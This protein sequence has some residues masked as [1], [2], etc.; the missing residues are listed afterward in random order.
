MYTKAKNKILIKIAVLQNLKEQ[1]I[2]EF[3]FLHTQKT[4]KAG[5]A[6]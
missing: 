3:F 4:I 5:P 1:K 2:E 6:V